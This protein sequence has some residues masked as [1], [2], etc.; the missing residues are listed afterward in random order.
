MISAGAF[1][2]TA[3]ASLDIQLGGAPG[4][5]DFGVVSSK[6]AA[7]LAGT[8]ASDL[9]NGYSLSTNSTFIPITFPSETGS[10]STTQLP[11]GRVSSSRTRLLSPTSFSPPSRRRR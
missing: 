3:G 2:Q 9:V 6:A 10:F 4:T 11:I 7:S 5:G 8:L 1:T